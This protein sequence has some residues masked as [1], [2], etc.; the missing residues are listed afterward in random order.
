MYEEY[1]ISLGRLLSKLAVE[2]KFQALSYTHHTGISK[3]HVYT[4]HNSFC[5][6]VGNALVFGHVLLVHSLDS[7]ISTWPQNELF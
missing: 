7:L 5:G 3:T 2:K 6:V 4:L 1:D